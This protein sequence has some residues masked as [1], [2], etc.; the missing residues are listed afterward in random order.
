[1]TEAYPLQWPAGKPRTV[2]PKPAAFHM[3]TFE[4]ARVELFRELKLLRAE[5]I[6]LSTNLQLRLDGFPYSNRAQPADRGVAVYFVLKGRAMT[7]PCDKWHRIEDNLRAI[8]KSIEAIRGIER[9]GGGDMVEQAFTGFVAL[10]APKAEKTR[11][12]HEVMGVPA[13]VDTA[14]IMARYR[15]LAKE[16]HPDIVGDDGKAMAELNVAYSQFKIERGV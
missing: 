3:K 12:W 9:W 7:F 10:P 13:H 15:A 2:N 11:P 14:G 5:N 16:R 4:Q 8:T 6:V 1:M